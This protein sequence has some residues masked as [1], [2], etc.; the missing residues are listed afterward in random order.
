M[1]LDT[2]MGS[3][4]VAIAAKLNSVDFIGIDKSLEYCKMVDSR[5]NT[6]DFK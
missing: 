5:L 6:Q 2:F 3:G 1:V 4:T